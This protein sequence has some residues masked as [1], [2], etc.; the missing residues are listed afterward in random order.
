MLGPSNRYVHSAYQVG[1]LDALAAGG[2]YLRE[3]GFRHS[4]GSA[5]RGQPDL[6]LLARPGR[7]PGRALRGR[8]PVR[9]HAGA[10]LVADDGV[11][12]GSGD[13]RHQGLSPSPDETLHELMSMAR[14]LA[15]DNEFDLTRLP[16]PPESDEFMS[17]TILRPPTPGGPHSRRRRT[18]RHRRHD[19]R[20]AARQPA[21]RGRPGSNKTIDPATLDLVSSVTAPCRVVAQMTT[22]PAT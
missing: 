14:S 5:H 2:E 4:G 10:R 22:S 6:R 7:P 3:L 16:R 15:D 11:R 13:R 19:H 20:R 17:I 12:A 9:L 18:R 1:D 8:R 21:D